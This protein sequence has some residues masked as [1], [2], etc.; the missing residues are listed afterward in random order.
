MSGFLSG[1]YR[2]D[3]PP[4]KSSRLAT[5]KDRL[6]GFDNERNWKILD[7]LDIV[8]KEVDASCAQVALAWLL[9]K[10]TVASVIFG[11]RNATQLNDNLRAAELK[12]TDEMMQTL[13]EASALENIYPYSFMANIQ[14]RW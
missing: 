5:W 8:S 14:G 2:K 3:Q 11:A 6:K 9:R 7:A 13:D 10:D 12:L 4:P 1:K